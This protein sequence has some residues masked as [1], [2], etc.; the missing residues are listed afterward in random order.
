MFVDSR[1]N[2]GAFLG[3]FSKASEAGTKGRAGHGTG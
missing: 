3:A 2:L 1:N